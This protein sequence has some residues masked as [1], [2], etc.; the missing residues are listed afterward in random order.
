VK[1]LRDLGQDLVDKRLWP[2]AVALALALVAIPLLLKSSPADPSAKP[3]AVARGGAAALTAATEG[4]D[5][6]RSRLRV[7]S[8]RDPFEQP[9]ASASTTPQGDGTATPPSGGSSS[10]AGAGSDAGGSA[11]SDGGGTSS[12]SGGST[13]GGSAAGSERRT[14][15]GG[16]ATARANS[17]RRPATWTVDV[18]FGPAGN[19]RKLKAVAPGTV[20][21]DGD[22]PLLIFVGGRSDGGTARFLLAA[23]VTPGAGDGACSPS[24]DLC[25]TLTM[26]AGQIRTLDVSTGSGT[27]T[28]LLELRAIRRR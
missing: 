10:S 6:K 13:T 5:P 14:A 27:T 28:Y 20:V 15:T 1:F 9:F 23:G 7:R 8:A 21:A 19:A 12:S 26:R 18:R 11:S 24:A 16:T 22:D 25:R 3:A 2:V 17:N 4:Q